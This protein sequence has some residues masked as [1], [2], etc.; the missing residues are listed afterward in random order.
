M[1]LLRILAVWIMLA[2]A[3]MGFAAEQAAVPAEAAGAVE[4]AT[5]HKG[6]H[7]E[8][9]ISQRA[10]KLRPEGFVTNSMI[11]T[12][13]VAL[14]LILFAQVA[15]RNMKEIPDGKQNFW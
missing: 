9:T 5:E 6:E 10:E 14:G 2:G 3:P 13:V 4:H 15:T 8:H 7:T 1:R 12:W 11:V